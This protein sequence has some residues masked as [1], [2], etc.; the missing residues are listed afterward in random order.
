MNNHNQTMPTLTL[1]VSLYD[2]YL[3][4]S[5]LSEQERQEFLE[6]LWNIVCEFVFLGFGIN[7]VQ[8]VIEESFDAE[9]F[10]VEESSDRLDSA[11]ETQAVRAFVDAANDMIE[12]GANA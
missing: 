2:H 3:E 7:T 1:D 10:L 9:K 8:Q 11:P 5:N 4:N 12:E 6:L